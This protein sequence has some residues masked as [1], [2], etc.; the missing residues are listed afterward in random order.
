[1]DSTYYQTVRDL[2][3]RGVDDEYITGWACGYLRNPKREEQRL[4]ERYEAGYADGC[5]GSVAS[6]E[7]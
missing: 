2:E 4:S 6:A 1:M 5:T 7:V 3:A